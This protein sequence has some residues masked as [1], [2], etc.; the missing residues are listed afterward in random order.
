MKKIEQNKLNQ[1]INNLILIIKE[2]Q[3]LL[4]NY[5]RKENWN[6]LMEGYCNY[7]GNNLIDK[8]GYKKTCYCMC[9]E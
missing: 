3:R 5:D 8:K 7:C 1:E 2:K 9:D 6:I 4:T